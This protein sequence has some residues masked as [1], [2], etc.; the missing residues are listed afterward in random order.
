MSRWLRGHRWLAGVGASLLV[1]VVAAVALNAVS[2]AR[3]RSWTAD[4]VAQGGHVERLTRFRD[5]N[6][7]LTQTSD[8]VYRCV[9]A[10]G[11]LI[12]ERS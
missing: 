7:V 4:C 11:G 2:Q 6:P 3:A 12:S 8:P 9:S 1:L 10:S 5:D